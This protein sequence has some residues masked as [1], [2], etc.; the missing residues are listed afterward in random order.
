MG[1]TKI[2]WS[3]FTWSPITGCTPLSEG[4]ANCYARQMAQRLKG[5]YGYPKVN[6][7]R[8]TFHQDKLYEPLHWRKPRRIFVCSMGDLFHEDVKMDW[9][10]EVWQV[11]E[12]CPQHIFMILTKRPERMKSLLAGII[13]GCKPDHRQHIWLGVTAENQ[14]RADERIPIL[15]EVPAKI[16]FVSFEPLL[17]A[18]GLKRYGSGLDW[19]IAGCESGPN[20]R[21]A[22]AWWFRRLKDQCQ[23]SNTAFFLKQ[24][25]VDGKIVKCPKLDGKV[26]AE[27]PKKA[28]GVK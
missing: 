28:R 22:E 20:R 13:T 1:R 15:L 11:M 16:K 21:K 19:I 3:D 26:W 9:I 5:R 23:Y 8:V 27:Y 14:K 7:F 25:E 12:R 2:E 4:C 10:Y 17:E 6:P 24:M 18:C